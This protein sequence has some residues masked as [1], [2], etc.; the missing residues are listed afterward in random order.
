[1]SLKTEMTKP[2]LSPVL[3]TPPLEYPVTLEEAKTHLRVDSAEEDTLI[4]AL[5]AAAV[6]HMDGPTG[7]LGRCIMPQ[8]WSQE[9]ETACGDLVLPLAPVSSITSIT[10]DFADY[11]LLK[12]GRGYFLRLNDD[13]SWPTGAVVVEFAAGYSDVPDPLR[14]AMLLHI[15]TLFEHRE[16]LAEGRMKPTWAYETLTAPYSV[17][18]V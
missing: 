16:T 17:V 3:V 15:G 9:Y 5:I 1:M 13:A 8:T 18:G 4:T 11:R 12:D 7:V 2:L 14:S 6:G 10:D